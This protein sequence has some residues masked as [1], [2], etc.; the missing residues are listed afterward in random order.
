MRHAG[1]RFILILG[2]LVFL[3]PS[4]FSQIRWEKKT[5][6]Y[7]GTVRALAVDDYLGIVYAGTYGNGVFHSLDQATN[8]W[9]PVNIGIENTYVRSL[10]VDNTT[11]ILYAGTNYSGIYR[12]YDQGTSWSLISTTDIADASVHK[13][14]VRLL[15]PDKS[16]LA[17]TGDI[18]K[19]HHPH[20]G[21][22]NM[23]YNN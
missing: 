9:Q 7:G 19:Q 21:I 15:R 2:L 16:G 17:M 8:A 10:A 23:C 22:D 11:G 13:R 4:V 5:A 1:P 6:R 18:D 14:S 12:S 3:S 20:R